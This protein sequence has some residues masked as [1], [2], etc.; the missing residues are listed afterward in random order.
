M[1]VEIYY[2]EGDWLSVPLSDGSGYGVCLVVRMNQRNGNFYGFLF[3][4][5]FPALPAMH[6]IAGITCNDVIGIELIC[7]LA[8][9]Y[10]RWPIIMSTHPWTRAHWPLP[11][12]CTAPILTWHDEDVG[13]DEVFSLEITDKLI[14]QFIS[15]LDEFT[16][17]IL[18]DTKKILRYFE[19]SFPANSYADYAYIEWLF[20]KWFNNP[21]EIPQRHYLF[22]FDVTRVLPM[23]HQTDYWEAMAG[24][25]VVTALLKI[26]HRKSE[27]EKRCQ[28]AEI[29]DRQLRAPGALPPG[30]VY[31][32]A[33]I[34]DRFIVWYWHGED[35]NA[36]VDAVTPFLLTFPYLAVSYLVKYLR[37]PGILEE[38]MDLP[39]PP[40]PVRRAVRK[41]KAIR[42][43]DAVSIPPLEPTVF[44]NH[45]AAARRGTDGDCELL[46]EKLMAR[47]SRGSARDIIAFDRRLHLLLNEAYRWDLWGAAYLINGGASDDGFEYFRGWLI[48][49]GEQV[50]RR[51]LSDP[52]S[53][54]EVMEPGVIAECEP[55]LYTARQAYETKTDEAF[56][57]LPREMPEI[58]GDAWTEEDLPARFPRLY[59][60]I[61]QINYHYRQ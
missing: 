8:A 49:Q 52:Q 45:L 23:P 7:S 21:R 61:T 60:R 29:L 3:R 43:E 13:T 17:A 35:A 1:A 30:V 16:T 51:A 39:A 42:Q 55:M 6:D 27:W 57:D 54:A 59:A 12:S 19:D 37:P 26:P 18:G 25:Q 48:A 40:E 34:H 44:W 31:D 9:E 41:P 56:P 46:T 24:Q 36:I 22:H 4:K 38:R 53:L 15:G 58:I 11:P 28:A 14:E 10:D 47:L 50:F 5:K 33:V 20:T 32:G 2:Q